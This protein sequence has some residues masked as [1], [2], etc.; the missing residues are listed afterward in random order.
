MTDTIPKA[1]LSVELKA[2]ILAA[3]DAYLAAVSA[4]VAHLKNAV[5]DDLSGV[6]IA[7]RPEFDRLESSVVAEIARLRADLAMG[8]PRRYAIAAVLVVASAA[9]MFGHFIA[10]LF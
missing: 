4:D 6:A 7:G 8:K 5:S 9:T 1:A 3:A 2:A 10:H